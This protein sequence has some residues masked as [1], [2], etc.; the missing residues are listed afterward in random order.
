MGRDLIVGRQG[1]SLLGEVL[2]RRFSIRSSF[3]TVRVEKKKISWIHL[4]DAPVQAQDEIWLTT[5]DRLT[6]AV[7]PRTVRFKTDD[8]EQLSVPRGAIHSIVIGAGFSARA[9]GLR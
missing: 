1:D 3:G 5:G 7:E 2:E 9:R 6:G 8:G 4:K